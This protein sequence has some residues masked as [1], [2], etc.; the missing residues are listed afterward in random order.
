[1]KTF[2]ELKYRFEFL[3]SALW[4][5]GVTIGDRFCLEP[6]ISEAELNQYEKKWKKKLPDEMRRFFLEVAGKI[7]FDWR[8]VDENGDPASLQGSLKNVVHESELLVKSSNDTGWPV[9]GGFVWSLKQMDWIY[10]TFWSDWESAFDEEN[11]ISPYNYL[12]SYPF[13]DGDAGELFC[14]YA[15]PS[16]ER[17]VFHC[18]DTFLG[19]W[20]KMAD[21]FEEFWNN[22][23]LV[24]CPYF[25][26]YECFYN[27]K[28]QKIDPFCKDAITW[29]Q[30]LE[31]DHLVNGKTESSPP[32][33]PF[34]LTKVFGW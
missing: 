27:V 18:G 12:Y 15:P 14:F 23:S 5:K 32:P 33:E 21:S 16:G 7:V 4:K 34:T 24:G 17:A 20:H 11:P 29:R 6:P 10:E 2:E 25:N 22:W 13:I 3:A 9:S 19:L 1:M 8:D 26:S 30:V 31:I 28:L